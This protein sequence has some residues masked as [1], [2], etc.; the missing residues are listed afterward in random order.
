[1]KTIKE[2]EQEEKYNKMLK[3]KNKEI[4]QLKEKIKE[5]ERDIEI[6][7]DDDD[8]DSVWMEEYNK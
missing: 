6:L 5:L 7:T 2:L 8:N 4:K 3:K 1:M